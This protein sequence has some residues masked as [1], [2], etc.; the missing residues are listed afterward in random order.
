MG[1]QPA[2]ENETKALI[3]IFQEYGG[4]GLLDFGQSGR[5]IVYYH[6]EQGL[7][8]LP[9]SHRLARHMQRTSAYHLEKE[10]ASGIE[11]TKMGTLEQ[12][13]IQSV[14]Q[15]VTMEDEG[16]QNAVKNIYKE[17]RLLPLEYIFSLK[18][19]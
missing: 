16:C 13:Y 15:P 8:L 2:S 4:K 3:R 1:E 10:S 12:Y 9:R 17:I 7:G 18:R 5:E 14:K 6:S 19:N 11:R